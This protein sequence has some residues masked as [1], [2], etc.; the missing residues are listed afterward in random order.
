MS[1]TIDIFSTLTEIIF[2]Q[3]KAYV[4]QNKN[5]Y[6]IHSYSYWKKAISYKTFE[7]FIVVKNYTIS[8]YKN[9]GYMAIRR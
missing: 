6:L 8:I 9:G 3:I 4:P 2:K 1:Y 7:F 5:I